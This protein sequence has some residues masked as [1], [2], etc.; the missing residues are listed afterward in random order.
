MDRDSRLKAELA[1]LEQAMLAAARDQAAARL[2]EAKAQVTA[3]K[4]KSAAQVKAL[5]DRARA[6]GGDAAERTARHRL[7][8]ARRQ[9]RT[10]VL[11]AERAAYERLL[12]EAV[13]ATRSLPGHAEYAVLEEGLVEAAKALLG[14][15]AK[16]TRNPA[17]L[18]GVEGRNGHR[19]VD[20]TLPALAHRCVARMGGQVARLWS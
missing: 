18:G 14:P 7:L 16:I 20:L 3:T 13:A 17:G 4:E 2:R 15:A 9:A 12:T 8:E 1:P 5:L 10:L 19:L 6:E 11:G